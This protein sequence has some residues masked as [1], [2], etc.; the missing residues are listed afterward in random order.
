MY[1]MSKWRGIQLSWGRVWIKS[2][3]RL[4]LGRVYPWYELAHHS[5][6]KEAHVSPKLQGARHVE[7]VFVAAPK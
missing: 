7:D 2:L 3:I 6:T 5:S 4:G 1:V